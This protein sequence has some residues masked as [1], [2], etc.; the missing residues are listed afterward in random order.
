MVASASREVVFVLKTDLDQSV[1]TGFEDIAKRA[2]ASQANIDRSVKQSFDAEKRA[3]Q[4]RFR[5]FEREIAQ[6]E[7][8]QK[9]QQR[10]EE[11]DRKDAVRA[12]A[13]ASRE[14][15]RI[16]RQ[17]AVR[18]ERDRRDAV[19]ARQAADR[20][21]VRMAREVARAESAAAREA[22]KAQA[23]TARDRMRLDR[24]AYNAA[25]NY[26]RSLYRL[27]ASQES[28][29]GGAMRLGRG[30][31]LMFASGKRQ[32]EE[33][34]RAVVAIQ[35]VYDAIRG[36]GQILRA[37]SATYASYT[38]A[39]AAAAA[40]EQASA[41]AASNAARA[42]TADAAAAQ[43]AAAA[44]LQLASAATAASAAQSAGGV[45]NVAGGVAQ[46]AGGVPRMG[47]FGRIAGKA[48][49]V[50]LSGLRG[51]G[52]LFGGGAT[53]GAGIVAGIPLAAAAAYKLGT[54]GPQEAAA[55][56]ARRAGRAE[57]G[58]AASREARTTAERDYSGI[59]A[60]ERERSEAAGGLRESAF[61]RGISRQVLARELQ[62]PDLGR[63]MGRW[64][65]DQQATKFG[66]VAAGAPEYTK[67]EE[68]I[69]AD[70][71]TGRKLIGQ[72]EA[73]AAELG[74]SVEQRQAEQQQAEKE[75][76]RYRMGAAVEQGTALGAAT[77]ADRNRSKWV[78]GTNWVHRGSSW[79]AGRY[80][81]DQLSTQGRL[82]ERASR[83]Q[84]E[85]Q[86]TAAI[87]GEKEAVAVEAA[88]ATEDALNKKRDMLEKINE[89]SQQGA[90]RDIQNAE[91]YISKL[92][93]MHEAHL[94][95]AD[96][97][98]RGGR[99]MVVAL[100]TGGRG[101]Q[102]RLIRA[103]ERAKSGKA[104]AKDL[105]MLS[106][107]ASGARQEELEKQALAALPAER[108]A[109]LEELAE[110]RG[111]G[112]KAAQA[113]RAKAADEEQ[114]IKEGEDYVIK[115]KDAALK[116]ADSMGNRL[117]KVLT[118]L[119]EAQEM[120]FTKAIDKLRADIM[121]RNQTNKTLSE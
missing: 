103:M 69:R 24:E 73:R 113:E 67:V 23:D 89:L 4:E 81:S 19:R 66:Y 31:A 105:A 88:K 49:G 41:V 52:S 2:K 120:Q 106:E 108:R 100:G 104:T 16:S 36:G 8:L 42:K 11:R 54:V 80:R 85:A 58:F 53:L 56:A 3:R 50:G 71:G 13:A 61:G 90:K 45:G 95:N 84:Q 77:A 98:E 62:G 32:S 21:R 114:R 26:Q 44:N 117:S 22:N 64:T 15:E 9:Q 75:A 99:Q 59:T 38:A 51:V 97:L 93:E 83:M 119:F 94:R 109:K 35:G 55:A 78:P 74:R 107:G 91:A 28:I 68:A 34:L 79:V 116:S 37:V 118:D 39:V 96:A 7:K 115:A 18:E 60:L 17:E 10:D 27:V 12:Q 70:R 72:Y 57:L 33:L 86:G 29:M 65:T 63:M 6:R 30:L 82:E 20:E 92:K 5:D 40:A 121:A 48:L 25:A 46:L 110:F 14:R 102:N 87:A 111:L 101:E 1:S 76:E 47:M 43:A 112:T